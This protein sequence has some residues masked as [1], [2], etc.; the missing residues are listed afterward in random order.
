MNLN[1]ANLKVVAAA[2]NDDIRRNLN[3][4]HVTPH[5]T[6]A[7]N[8]HILAR[9][10]LPT[11]YEP[12][13]LPVSCPTEAAENLKPFIIPTSGVKGLKTFKARSR[14]GSIPC[15]EDTLYIDVK[16]TNLNGHAKFA[17]T[18]REQT[19]TP[20]IRKIDAEYPETERI[21]PTEEESFHISLD[22]NYMITL[23]EIAKG[24]LNGPRNTKV[25]FWAYGK[26]KPFKITAA[27]SDT[28]QSMTALVMPLQ[29]DYEDRKKQEKAFREAA[30]FAADLL[31]ICEIYASLDLM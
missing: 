16:E 27:N 26:N 2:S 14:Y 1:T 30:Q 22:A 5:Y 28:G 25:E 18:D 3:G 20:I 6:E 31:C 11:Q 8:G 13:E 17:A 4:I 21:M 7:T 12:D 23:L 9:V 15:L 10:S 24:V 19:I 29:D